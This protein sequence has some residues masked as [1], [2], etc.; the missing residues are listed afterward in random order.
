MIFAVFDPSPLTECINCSF[1]TF[2]SIM[3]AH[4]EDS[5]ATVWTSVWVMYVGMSGGPKCKPHVCTVLELLAMNIQEKQCYYH[6]QRHIIKIIFIYAPFLGTHLQVRH[7]DEF[8]RMMAQTTRTRARMCLF[9]EFFTLLP[10]KGS[11]TPKTLNFGA[12]IGVF[13]PNSRNRKTCIFSKLLHRFQP[14]FAQ[15]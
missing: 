8:S 5:L 11:K 14:N 10:F 12:W 2:I 1:F 6:E 9:W 7:V 15:W 4:I 13:K 3:I